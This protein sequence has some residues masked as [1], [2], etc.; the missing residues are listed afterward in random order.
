L[1][2]D[3]CVLLHLPAQ[4]KHLTGK[5]QAP[6]YRKKKGNDAFDTPN[7]AFD[8]GAAREHRGLLDLDD[9]GDVGYRG[10]VMENGKSAMSNQ[11]QEDGRKTTTTTSFWAC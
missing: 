4:Q 5:N 11:H 1:H 2:L 3:H 10:E 7:E 6:S 8:F 9:A